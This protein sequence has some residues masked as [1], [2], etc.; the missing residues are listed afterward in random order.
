MI[1]NQLL[2]FRAKTFY[3]YKIYKTEIWGQLLDAFRKFITSLMRKTKLKL[4]VIGFALGRC[5][6][7]DRSSGGLIFVF[8]FL[9]L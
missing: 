1:M 6:V 4:G 3:M 5:E 2:L 8:L 9:F 7:N